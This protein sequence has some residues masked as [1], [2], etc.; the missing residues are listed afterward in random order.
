MVCL[1]AVLFVCNLQ[2]LSSGGRGEGGGREGCAISFRLKVWQGHLNV[3]YKGHF[4]VR[5]KTV[6]IPTFGRTYTHHNG[7]YGDLM[8]GTVR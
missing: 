6:N 4:P 2:D 8:G 5:P 1:S 3:E 7:C